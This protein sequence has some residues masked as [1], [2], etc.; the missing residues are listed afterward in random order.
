MINLPLVGVTNCAVPFSHE[1]LATATAHS[2]I[3]PIYAIQFTFC[4][5]H[6]QSLLLLGDEWTGMPVRTDSTHLHPLPDLSAISLR[7]QCFQRSVSTSIR[8]RPSSPHSQPKASTWWPAAGYS[9]AGV[10]AYL[11]MRPCGMPDRLDIEI[12]PYVSRLSH[13]YC[14]QALRRRRR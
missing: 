4:K 6:A 3:F 11:S 7:H 14:T 10:P 2:E 5:R 8:L 1:P 9:R 12:D 13:P